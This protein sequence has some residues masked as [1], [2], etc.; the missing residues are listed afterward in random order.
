[1]STGVASERI[2]TARS[3]NREEFNTLRGKL[4]Q[5]IEAFGLPA[6]QERAAK[7]VIR[8]VTWQSQAAMESA[9]QG[10]YKGNG[11]GAPA[12]NGRARTG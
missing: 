2:E 9:L 12:R 6:Q 11:T 5:A 7:G 1:M 4:F 8:D 10:Q 3:V